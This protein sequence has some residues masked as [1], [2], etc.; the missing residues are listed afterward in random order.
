MAFV[1][2]RRIFFYFDNISFAEM[3]RFSFCF[4][5]GYWLKLFSNGQLLILFWNG[6]NHFSILSGELL[7]KSSDEI[8]I[9]MLGTDVE[10]SMEVIRNPSMFGF[11]QVEGARNPKGAATAIFPTPPTLR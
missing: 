3:L 8:D 2:Y 9:E 6:N 10:L 7:P 1:L 5:F 4:K 11:C